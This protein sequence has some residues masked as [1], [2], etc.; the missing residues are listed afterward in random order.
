MRI[1]EAAI[2]DTNGKIYTGR[3]H[4]EIFKIMPRKMIKDHTQGF[5]TDDGRFVTRVEAADIAFICGQTDRIIHPLTS[6]D[7]W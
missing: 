5:M 3:R 7:L 2:M 1:K 4:H 6:E